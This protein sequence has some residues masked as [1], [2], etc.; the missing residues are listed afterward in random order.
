MP[1][2]ARR[3]ALVHAPLGAEWRSSRQARRIPLWRWRRAVRQRKW[4]AACRGNSRNHYSGSRWI[5]RIVQARS[6]SGRTSSR[7][8]GGGLTWNGSTLRGPAVFHVVPG[9]HFS[10]VA[11]LLQWVRKAVLREYRRQRRDCAGSGHRRPKRG[12]QQSTLS[13][14]RAGAW[15]LA[16]F[17]P[18]ATSAT[19]EKISRC[20]C[21]NRTF[22]P[23]FCAH[24]SN[25]VLHRCV[26]QLT[27]KNFEP[28]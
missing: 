11:K 5:W 24:A 12:R 28:P 6:H 21:G 16:G 19:A 13:S 10:P 26:N 9:S 4:S 15:H 27:H 3:L 17:V 2:A 23:D 18:K 14:H 1:I 20:G 7:R 8:R 22:A 25:T